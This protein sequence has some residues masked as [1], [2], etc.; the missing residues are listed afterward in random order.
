MLR[1]LLSYL[2]PINIYQKN[3]AIS[4]SIEV[5]WNNGQLVL[6]SKNTNYSY[7]SLQRILR[8]GLKKIGFETV[9]G[10]PL[11]FDELNGPVLFV[12]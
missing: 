2:V 1:R 4:K 11:L 3:S 6:D 9:T 10:F 5:N 12:V 7:G 8:I